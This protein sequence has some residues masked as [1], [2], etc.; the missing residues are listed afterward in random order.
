MLVWIKLSCCS[1]D[2]RYRTYKSWIFWISDNDFPVFFAP[3]VLLLFAAL[4]YNN[5]Y[6]YMHVMFQTGHFLSHFNY[7]FYLKY[8]QPV[9]WSLISHR[10][11][12]GGLR[13]HGSILITC[14]SVSL[15]YA[16]TIKC[17]VIVANI[18]SLRE[19]WVL[20]ILRGGNILM[21]V[22]NL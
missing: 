10:N 15:E 11:F 6:V 5:W 18:I 20:V 2:P 14:K 12:H 22:F 4:F 9:L 13:L 8:T 16:Y 17:T 1:W 3:W 21:I 7:L 19:C